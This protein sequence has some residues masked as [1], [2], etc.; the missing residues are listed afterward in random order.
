[1]AVLDFA[2]LDG[3]PDGGGD[4]IYEVKVPTPLKAAY[5]AGKGSAKGGQPATVGHVHGFG[6]TL[7]A[8]SKLTHG[9]KQR[10]SPR[11]PPFDHKTGKGYVAP[12][13]GH[14]HDA[15]YVKKSRLVL[16]LVEAL[17]GIAP[18]RRAG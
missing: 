13:K 4:V 18:G 14:Y 17:G 7:E 1:M 5:S 16:L 9:L 6:S 15:L 2:E 10:S 8:Y 12:H 3:D 11:D